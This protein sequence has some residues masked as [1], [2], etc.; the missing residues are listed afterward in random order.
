MAS[1]MKLRRLV[2]DLMS[3]IYPRV[4][5]VCGCSLVGDERCV[6]LHC[7]TEMPRTMLAEQ[8]Q[9]SFNSI[10][11]RVLGHSPIERAT[12]MFYYDPAGRYA[13]I[14]R[15]AKYGGRPRLIREMGEKYAAEI[16]DTGFFDGIDLILPVPMHRLK[17]FRRGYN[18]TESL[19]E[20]ISAV[21]GIP[22]GDNL[23]AHRHSAQAGSS[24]MVRAA[25]VKGK[26]Y[27][28]HP[29]ELSHKHILIV[30]DIITTGATVNGCCEAIHSALVPPTRTG[31][32]VP[33][34]VDAPY[35]ISIL[36]L[37]TTRLHG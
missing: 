25:N 9:T 27:V 16:K 8:K 10:H 35:R 23:R 4:C 24:R 28:V 19:A 29:D 31:E 22:V 5:E 34:A 2:D 30:D 18:Q 3:V 7:D 36:T 13:N 15:T 26:Y 37:A 20:G 32:T 1:L 21:T 17:Q 14:I 33:P 12:A 6:C 11:E